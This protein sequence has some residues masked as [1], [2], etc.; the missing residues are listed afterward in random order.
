MILI[1]NYKF[2]RANSYIYQNLGGKLPLPLWQYFSLHQL[3]LIVISD[4][5]S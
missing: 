3:E 2:V 4:L 1:A 5:R